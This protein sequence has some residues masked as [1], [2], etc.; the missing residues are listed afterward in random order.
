MSL[1]LLTTV[2]FER[3]RTRMRART[4]PDDAPAPP[5]PQTPHQQREQLRETVLARGGVLEEIETIT[6]DCP[7]QTARQIQDLTHWL[8]ARRV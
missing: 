4:L 3:L 2:V 8:E 1:S 5:P 7:A 6:G